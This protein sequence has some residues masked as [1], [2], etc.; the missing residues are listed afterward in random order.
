LVYPWIGDEICHSCK[1]GDEHLGESPKT[2]GI[3]QDGGYSDYILVPNYKHLIKLEVDFNSSA[4]LACSGLTAYT[5]IK[6][7]LAMPG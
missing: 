2:L 3:F 4:A 6:K 7:S 5:S 1:A